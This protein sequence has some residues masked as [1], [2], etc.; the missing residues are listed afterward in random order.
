MPADELTIRRAHQ[1]DLDLLVPLFE[2]YR[3]FYECAPDT[4]AA[5]AFLEERLTRGD[6]TIFVAID[7]ATT[8]GAGFVQLYPV[9]SSLQM[10]PAWVLNDLFVAP[11]YRGR[12]LSRRLM[13]AAR[14]LAAETGAAY[15]TLETARDNTTAQRLYESLGYK[16]DQA[17]LH[18]ELDV[19]VRDQSTRQ[20]A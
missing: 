16:A 6:S 9:F 2:G 18:Y 8:A 13:D 17:F 15:L 5:R 20:K 1:R 3:A 4:K 14:T 11:A 7:D 12:H 19:S 10:K